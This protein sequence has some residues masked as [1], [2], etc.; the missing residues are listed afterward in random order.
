MIEYSN[1]HAMTQNTKKIATTQTTITFLLHNFSTEGFTTVGFTEGKCI[2]YTK[3]RTKC[4][5][6][7]SD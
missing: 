5:V 6:L 1:Y 4:I 7:P 3:A 2:K